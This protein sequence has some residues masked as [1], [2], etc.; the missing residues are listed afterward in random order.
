MLQ[1]IIRMNPQD[2]ERYRED[3]REPNAKLGERLRLT[4]DR[5]LTIRELPGVRETV[6]H[7][8][9]KEEWEMGEPAPRPD[10]EEDDEHPQPPQPPPEPEPAPQAAGR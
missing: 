8:A 9:T 1:Y 10:E 5:I 2:Y 6:F 4:P 3:E 7:V